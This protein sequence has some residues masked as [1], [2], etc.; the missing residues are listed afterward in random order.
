MKYKLLS[1]CC[2]ARTKKSGDTRICQKCKG[3]CVLSKVETLDKNKK[4]KNKNLCL[5]KII[6]TIKKSK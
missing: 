6:T 1:D 4:L 5:T 3:F 2:L